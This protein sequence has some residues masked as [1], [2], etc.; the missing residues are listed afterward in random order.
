MSGSACSASIDGWCET[1]STPDGPSWCVDA[2]RDALRRARFH[3]RENYARWHEANALL[4]RLDVKQWTPED[5][6]GRCQ[7]CWR[8]N[9]IWHADHAV[10][11]EVM[12]GEG[13][14]LCPTCFTARAPYIIWRLYVDRTAA[15]AETAPAPEGAAAEEGGR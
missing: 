14:V 8:P 2:L 12:G 9:P 4:E 15:P 6:D 5:G 7:E 11:N 3:E 1:H 10:W 13:G